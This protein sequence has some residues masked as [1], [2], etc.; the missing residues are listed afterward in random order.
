MATQTWMAS[1]QSLD[2]PPGSVYDSINTK[3]SV[4]HC[5]LED[6]HSEGITGSGS[7]GGGK[8][9][10]LAPGQQGCSAGDRGSLQGAVRP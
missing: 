6:S 1:F 10:P 9:P 3:R 4:N 7:A 5:H 8:G 2:V